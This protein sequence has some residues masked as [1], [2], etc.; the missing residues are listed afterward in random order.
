MPR[1]LQRLG[2]GGA[3]LHR[4]GLPQ[5]AVPDGKEPVAQTSHRRRT[6]RAPGTVRGQEPR[7]AVGTPRKLGAKSAPRISAGAERPGRADFGF[8]CQRAGRKRGRCVMKT[9]RWHPPGYGGE[10]R[11]RQADRVK[12]D[13]GL[14]RPTACSPSP[15]TTSVSAGR[16]GSC[17]SAGRQAVW[18][19]KPRGRRARAVIGFPGG[20]RTPHRGPAGVHLPT[21]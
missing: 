19:E 13:R 21:R 2:A 1:L 12:R 6:R 5:L 9:M 3:A 18:A 16:S 8:S 14:A 15:S 20:P 17:P 7:S 10:R 11:R 4:R